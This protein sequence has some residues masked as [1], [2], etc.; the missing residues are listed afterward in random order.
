MCNKVRSPCRSAVRRLSAPF[1]EEDR[2]NTL[3][4][5]RL[6]RVLLGSIPG[7]RNFTTGYEA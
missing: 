2:I 4:H 5:L 6:N 1:E 7:S 3:G